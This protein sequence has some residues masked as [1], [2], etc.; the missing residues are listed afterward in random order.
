METLGNTNQDRIITAINY[1]NHIL[2][3]NRAN[4]RAYYE[5]NKEAVKLK[6]K[7]AYHTKY[8]IDPNYLV[9]RSQYSKTRYLTKKLQ[10]RL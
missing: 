1:Y 6:N 2:E 10:G 4:Q 7:L 5:K 9:K 3:R 8:C